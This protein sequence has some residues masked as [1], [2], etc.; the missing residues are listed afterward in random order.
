MV[1]PDWTTLLSENTKVWEMLIKLQKN[2]TRRSRIMISMSRVMYMRLDNLPKLSGKI[3]LML[4]LELPGI[5]FVVF[6]YNL[7]EIG[8]NNKIIILNK[9]NLQSLDGKKWKFLMKLLWKLKKKLELLL[10]DLKKMKIR[11]IITLIK[12]LLEEYVLHITDSESITERH[13]FSSI[14][15]LPTMLRNKLWKLTLQESRLKWMIPK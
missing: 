15:N 12:N 1:K 14:G 7:K 2:G 11:S 13:L 4:V 10:V 3:A 8:F 9:Y 6:I 5:L